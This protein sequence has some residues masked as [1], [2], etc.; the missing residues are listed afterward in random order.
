MGIYLA[1]DWVGVETAYPKQMVEWPDCG[2][3]EMPLLVLGST[4]AGF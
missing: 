4:L 2:V 1:G 3:I